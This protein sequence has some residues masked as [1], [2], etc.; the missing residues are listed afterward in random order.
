MRR[1]GGDVCAAV[2]S[3]TI[4]HRRCPMRSRSI[5]RG[6]RA[7]IAV[8]AALSWAAL[9]ARQALGADACLL[10]NFGSPPASHQNVDGT[11]DAMCG[12]GSEN[13]AYAGTFNISIDGGPST[14]GYCVDLHHPISGG[15]CEPQS[16]QPAYPCEVTYILTHFYPSTAPA[17]STADEAAAVQAAIWHF[18]DCFTLTHAD[19]GNSAGVIARYNQII[20]AATANAD[21]NCNDPV[22]PHTVTF[23]P[24][25]AVNT[26]PADSSHAVTVTV[27]D[28]N[29]QPMPNR[30][31]TV[32]VSGG[33]SGPYQFNG[34]TDANGQFLVSYTNNSGIA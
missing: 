34:T 30:P 12:G 8:F 13:G 24:A 1:V 9:P 21:P 32:T 20:A 17:L 2:G 19:G 29:D 22:V 23:T 27:L 6:V 28:N 3:P 18:T 26:L 11:I 5:P 31:V 33:P 7:S 4:K 25:T 16:Q 14:L 15:D 10:N